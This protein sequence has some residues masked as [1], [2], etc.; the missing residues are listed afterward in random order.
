MIKVLSGNKKI[1]IFFQISA[2]YKG[3]CVYMHTSFLVGE[4]AARFLGQASYG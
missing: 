2:V 3:V 4:I 1:H